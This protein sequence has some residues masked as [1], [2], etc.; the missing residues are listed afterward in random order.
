MPDPPAEYR[1][2]VE[3]YQKNA[4]RQDRI[5]RT[6]SH[7]ANTVEARPA[8]STAGLEFGCGEGAHCPQQAGASGLD[9]NDGITEK[10]G[11]RKGGIFGTT[12][13]PAHPD[14]GSAPAPGIEVQSNREHLSSD[15]KSGAD[16]KQAGNPEDAKGLA[17]SGF[18][19][20]PSRTPDP[21]TVEKTVGQTPAAM[22]LRS[23]IPDGLRQNT[24][25]NAAL[26]WYDKLEKSQADT[27]REIGEIQKQITAIGAGDTVVQKARLAEL[28]NQNRQQQLDQGKIAQQ[29]KKRVLDL[30]M[31]WIEMPQPSKEGAESAQPAQ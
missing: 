25:I 16:A 11:T 23:H 21:I 7:I 13:N 19:A 9:F 31:V 29:I 8:P 22:D 28:E 18:D 17:G 14:L 6:L 24:E 1:K 26:A 5:T 20:K 2:F 30:Q 3:E 12:S 27:A 15:S 10:G 4:A